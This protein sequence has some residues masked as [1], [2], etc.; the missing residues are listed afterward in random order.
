MSQFQMTLGHEWQ[1]KKLKAS[2]VS[3]YHILIKC[4]DNFKWAT[5][6]KGCKSS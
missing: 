4:Y 3:F 5:N 6:V 2:N 1:T